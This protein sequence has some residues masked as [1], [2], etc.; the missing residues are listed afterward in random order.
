MPVEY[1]INDESGRNQ[2]S[3][4][5]HELQLLR[6]NIEEEITYNSVDAGRTRTPR[7]DELLERIKEIELERIQKAFG[8]IWVHNTSPL[9]QIVP[10]LNLGL[11]VGKIVDL[12]RHTDVAFLKEHADDIFDWF[13]KRVNEINLFYQKTDDIPIVGSD[14]IKKIVLGRK[15]ELDERSENFEDMIELE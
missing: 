1:Y 12:M 4:E 15:E 11:P 9:V 2:V 13:E 3:R 14:R 10:H 5:E 6:D 8:K 7:I